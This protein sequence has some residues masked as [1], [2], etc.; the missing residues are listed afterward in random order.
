MVG[1]ALCGRPP[2]SKK[3]CSEQLGRPRSA[4]LQ[5]GCCCLTLWIEERRLHNGGA[6][7]MPHGFD[8]DLELQTC[9]RSG[10]SAADS[11]ERN[12]PFQR[13][14][15]RGRRRLA[16]LNAFFVNRDRDARG[17]RRNCRRQ[18][19]R[20]VDTLDL[21]PIELESDNLTR[22]SAFLFFNER[23]LAHETI[24]IKIYESPESHLKGRISLLINQRLFAAVEVDVNQQQQKG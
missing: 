21:R 14:R 24:L 9:A 16:N 6:H 15:P 5:N 12:H 11:R 20:F 13:R 1:T 7:V 22:R 18:S 4:A 19:H 3:A 10:V 8:R 17:H 23:R 2:P